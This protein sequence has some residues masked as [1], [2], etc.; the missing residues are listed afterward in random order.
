MHEQALDAN[1]IALQG[2]L[3]VTNYATGHDIG[4]F[5]SSGASCTC[6]FLCCWCVIR[7]DAIRR[8]ATRRD[9]FRKQQMTRQ[10]EGREVAVDLHN[11]VHY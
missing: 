11:A 5:G 7:R 4:R 1:W 2:V 9:A 3:G 6:C 8:N 10:G